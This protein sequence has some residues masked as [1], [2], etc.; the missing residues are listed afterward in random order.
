MAHMLG[1]QDAELALVSLKK[2]D[3]ASV[4]GSNVHLSPQI[5]P[6]MSEWV[7][8]V[9]HLTQDGGLANP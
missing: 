2:L 3:Q 4:L 9:T 7:E 5:R 6:H 8:A 1:K